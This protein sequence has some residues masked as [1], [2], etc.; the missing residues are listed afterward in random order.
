[1][2]APMAFVQRGAV[3]SQAILVEDVMPDSAPET[4]ARLDTHEAVCAERYGNLVRLIEGTAHRVGRLEV[5]VV[6]VAGSMIVGMAGLI[7]TL[8]LKLGRAA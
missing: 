1:M 4:S 7:I 8:A 2:P 5:L 3:P 6:I